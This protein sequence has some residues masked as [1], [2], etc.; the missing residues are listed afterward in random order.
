MK[1]IKNLAKYHRSVPISRKLIT[2][3]KAMVYATLIVIGLQIAKAVF[4]DSII[5]PMWDFFHTG[6]GKF[7]L[8]W[9]G[10]N[11]IIGIFSLK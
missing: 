2:L 3:I 7:V 11:V 10:L 1:A 5:F 4:L 8:G 6:F 9:L